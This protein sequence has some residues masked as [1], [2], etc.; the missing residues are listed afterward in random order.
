MGVYFDVIARPGCVGERVVMMRASKGF[1]GMAA[2]NVVLFGVLMW[3]YVF[4]QAC[5][6]LERLGIR[7]APFDDGVFNRLIYLQQNAM[8]GWNR[9][10]ILGGGL[11]LWSSVV[12]GVRS[13]RWG[14]NVMGGAVCVGMSG[15]FGVVCWLALLMLLIFMQDYYG[16]FD[17]ME[18]ITKRW[19]GILFGGMMVGW[20]LVYP[21]L[22]MRGMDRQR[23]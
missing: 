4:L 3:G 10:M 1:G 9:F 8:G 5:I 16:L 14:R 2:M 6:G 17:G 19:I 18:A 21:V 15:L 23:Y 7:G 13:W 20:G 11:I 22:G 12:G